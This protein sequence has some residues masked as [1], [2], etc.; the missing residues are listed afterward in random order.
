MT[1]RDRSS[2]GKGPRT[3]LARE[4]PR[5]MIA[6]PSHHPRLRRAALALA[7]A[8][9]G[10]PALAAAQ[11]P[12]RQIDTSRGPTSELYIRKRPPA[13]E[14]PVLSAELKTLLAS[15]EKK[16]DDKR[17]EAIGLLRAFLARHGRPDLDVSFLFMAGLLHYDF[18]YNV[19]ELEACA[20]RAIALA[21]GPTLEV[22]L[23][24][25]PIR[26]AMAGYGEE[27]SADEPSAHPVPH[28]KGTPTEAELRALLAEHAGNVAAVG[29]TLGKARMQIHRWVERYGID[30][31]EYRAGPAENEK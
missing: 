15:T 17:L 22:P 7:C 1:E 13:P 23:L 16:R 29:R 12:E 27:P 11:A 19:R 20:K 6:T 18:P 28:H 26:E 24:P 5:G 14:A 9:A 4:N 31:D 21:D 2:A 25:E 30:L 8:A 3:T 10:W